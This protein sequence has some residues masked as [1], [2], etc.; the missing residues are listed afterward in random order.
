MEFG[1]DED[2][3]LIAMRN[4]PSFWME[5]FIWFLCAVVWVSKAGLAGSLS[6]P[7]H[8]VFLGRSFFDVYS[9]TSRGRS[10]SRSSVKVASFGLGSSTWRVLR[11]RWLCRSCL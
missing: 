10:K 5:V 6:W 1:K 4:M 11:T 7:Q 2:V 3:E 8:L 9:A